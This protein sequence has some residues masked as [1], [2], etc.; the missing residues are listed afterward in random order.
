[1]TAAYAGGISY[2]YS[3]AMGQGIGSVDIP[4]LGSVDGTVALALSS[5]ASN[6]LTSMVGQTIVP[7]LLPFVPGSLDQAYVQ[8]VLYAGIAGLGTDLICKGVIPYS[9][10]TDKDLFIN[11]FV[12][13]LA[14]NYASNM[15]NR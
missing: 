2:A 8:P 5:A 10:I 11:G 12:S 4:L 15:M 3:K 6:Y 1:M 9:G 7:N 14:G 13:S